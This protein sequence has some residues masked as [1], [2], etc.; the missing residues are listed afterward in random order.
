M[1]GGARWQLQSENI[2]GMK[3]T[4]W[5][6]KCQIVSQTPD[7]CVA[8]LYKQTVTLTFYS[9]FAWYKWIK[10]IPLF[11]QLQHL[12]VGIDLHVK[13]Q[14][15]V[16]QVLIVFQL[17]VHLASHA[18]QLLLLLT[19]FVLPNL[20][21]PVQS[22]LQL[23]KAALQHHFL[24]EWKSNIRQMLTWEPT[25]NTNNKAP[26]NNS[27]PKR[28]KYSQSK[29]IRKTKKKK[30]V[31]TFPNSNN[32]LHHVTEQKE[33]QRQHLPCYR[34]LYHEHDSEAESLRS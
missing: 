6:Q 18:L 28:H 3:T 22:P 32:F 5:K 25:A 10:V 24:Y 7:I 19:E 27:M 33:L 16:K 9:T 2:F 21:L 12:P 8:D 13:S 26:W 11:L 15:D 14:L 23:L 4:N 31:S 34:T 30:K 1:L 17:V 29:V 20:P